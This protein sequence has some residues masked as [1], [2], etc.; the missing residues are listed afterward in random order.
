MTSEKADSDSDSKK[1]KVG[2]IRPQ[3][4]NNV[5]EVVRGVKRHSSDISRN[6][7]KASLKGKKENIGKRLI[8][9]VINESTSFSF[10]NQIEFSIS[11]SDVLRFRTRGLDCFSNTIGASF[12]NCPTVRSFL[13]DQDRVQ[14]ELMMVFEQILYNHVQGAGAGHMDDVRRILT[15]A[16]SKDKNWNTE[17]VQ[18]AGE[19][20]H[21]IIQKIIEENP[22]AEN[23]FSTSYFLEPVCP[24]GKRGGDGGCEVPPG[25]QHGVLDTQTVMS[26][27]IDHGESLV[28]CLKNSMKLVD[29]LPR[30]CSCT[31]HGQWKVNPKVIQ[32]PD[33]MIIQL[34]RFSNELKKIQKGITIPWELRLPFSENLNYRFASAS[35]HRGET[36]STGHYVSIVRQ[37]DKFFEVN[38][39]KIR[40]ISPDEAEREIQV[41]YL[42]FYEK[43]QRDDDSP[44][45]LPKRQR[46]VDSATDAG[47][48]FLNQLVEGK[49]CFQFANL[50]E[51][52]AVHLL[53]MFK[54]PFN[55]N[56]SLCVLKEALVQHVRKNIE[57][58]IGSDVDRCHSLFCRLQLTTTSKKN[59]KVSNQTKP[60]KSRI[61]EMAS[62]IGSK[63][64][65]IT[66]GLRSVDISMESNDELDE[67][68]K[69]GKLTTYKL[70]LSKQ[71]S[72]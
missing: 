30:G 27:P 6:V 67:T 4:I 29:N 38:D 31:T 28:D 53:N 50:K 63:I 18:C 13:E 16:G 25:L 7:V 55:K 32:H 37:G 45:K 2:P 70:F 60:S 15:E 12:L 44:Q 64:S 8:P 52:E 56:D 49:S 1:K 40:C 35:V 3:L 22:Q 24:G 68:L 51:A 69:T 14:G 58:R 43:I 23:L 59:Q 65:Q 17:T 5:S 20:L 34:K 11:E 21:D 26:V 19:F 57:K 48:Q 62:S 72:L 39:Q 33:V 46:T 66:D 47:D 54:I 9:S 61:S 42:V 41:A 71:N 10:N 36:L